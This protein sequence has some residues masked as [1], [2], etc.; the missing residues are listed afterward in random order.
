MDRQIVEEKTRYLDESKKLEK[1]SRR[2]SNIQLVLFALTAVF[3]IAAFFVSGG[4]WLC[5]GAAICFAL[6]FFALTVRHSHVESR[7]NRAERCLA[8]IREYEARAGDG[9]REFAETGAEFSLSR[10]EKMLA[11]DLDLLGENS[12]FQ[13]M[14][15]AKSTGGKRKLLEAL[16]SPGQETAVILKTQDAVR[17]LRDDFEFQ[18]NFQ[19]KLNVFSGKKERAK[20]EP[21]GETGL[22]QRKR[23]ADTVFYIISALI[24]AGFAASIVL[25]CFRQCSLLVVVILILLQLACLQ[26][27]A[28]FHRRDFAGLTQASR[29]FGKLMGAFMYVENRGFHS[30]RL[31]ELQKDIADADMVLKKVSRLSGWND[32]RL[33]PFSD[34]LFNS[35]FPFNEI[36]LYVYRRIFQNGA[37]LLQKGMEALEEIEK[38]VSLTTIA[39]VKQNVSLPRFTDEL[40]IQTEQIKHPLLVEEDCVAND[41]SCGEAVNIITGS[42]MSGKSTFMRTIGINYVLA[43]AGTFVNAKSFSG[44]RMKLFTSIRIE[45]NISEGISTFLAELMRMKDILEYAG[46]DNVRPMLIFIDEIFKGTNYNDRLLGAREVLKRL[47]KYP[48]IVFLTTHDFELCEEADG[49]IQ[50]YHFAE[51]YEGERIFFDC[52]IKKGRCTTTNAR[53]LMKQI[54]L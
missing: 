48:C 54:G 28:A 23:A 27:Y 44:G 49:K 21:L 16:L 33:N 32:Y 3:L 7:W 22:P 38:L 36:L 46:K 50:N 40:V 25:A 17:E 47:E 39:M 34:I 14:N 29:C 6:L 53:Y 35:L 2:L 11:K 52:K 31:R 12:L 4:K 26:L 24:F 42:N 18:L 15:T 41:F 1:R 10:E 20:E 19:E 9:W 30:D 45:D 43:C 5:L 37:S 13:Y 8:V 51:E